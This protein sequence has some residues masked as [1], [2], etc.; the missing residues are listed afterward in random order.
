MKA[1][2]SREELNRVTSFVRASALH[3]HAD[4]LALQDKYENGQSLSHA[5][6]LL[7]IK[8]ATELSTGVDSHV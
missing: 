3:L 5:D 1:R 7:I 2:N 4:V 6:W 8:R